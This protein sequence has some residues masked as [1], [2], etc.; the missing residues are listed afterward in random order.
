MPSIE[1]R[2]W[3]ISS[4]ANLSLYVYLQNPALILIIKH[5]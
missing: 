3:S 5:I 4:L 1:I 2:L